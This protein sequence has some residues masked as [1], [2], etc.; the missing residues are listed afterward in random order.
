[1]SCLLITLFFLTLYFIQ[2]FYKKMDNK[3]LS[4]SPIEAIVRKPSY[5]LS[6][7]IDIYLISDYNRI[8]ETNLRANLLGSTTI[9]FSIIS[10]LSINMYTNNVKGIKDNYL[11][12]AKIIKNDSIAFYKKNKDSDSIQIL[13]LLIPILS[14]IE[15]P[16]DEWFEL[17]KVNSAFDSETISTSIVRPDISDKEIIMTELIPIEEKIA[18]LSLLYIKSVIS[19]VYTKLLSGN[20]LLI[21]FSIV[22]I[23]LNYI[24]PKN[25][26]INIFIFNCSVAIISYAI[27]EIIIII[28]FFKQEANEELVGKQIREHLFDE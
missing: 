15:L 18:E 7:A 24:L 28:S 19:N 3:L 20:F 13:K 2:F 11:N 12:L 6:I 22:M 9:V 8:L 27:M 14:L 1:M 25:N 10:A 21:E 26:I 17:E 4:I 23:S 16:L 5:R